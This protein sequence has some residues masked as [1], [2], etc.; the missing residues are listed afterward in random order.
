MNARMILALGALGVLDAVASLTGLVRAGM[1]WPL[2]CAIAVVIGVVCGWKAP[3]R[4]FLHGLLAGGIAFLIPPVAQVLFFDRYVALNPKVTQA[5]ATLPAGVSP[6]M[7]VTVSAF[8]L[9]LCG[10]LV[11]GLLAWIV[12]KVTRRNPRTPALT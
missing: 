11:V 7:V 8:M 12:S 6:K 5:F 4:P 9:A 2:S 1:E 3:N 10:G